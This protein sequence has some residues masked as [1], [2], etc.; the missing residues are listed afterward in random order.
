M[1]AESSSQMEQLFNFFRNQQQPVIRLILTLLLRQNLRATIMT[2]VRFLSEGKITSI[3]LSHRIS[4]ADNW[5]LFTKRNNSL[6]ANTSLVTD[7][8]SCFVWGRKKNCENRRNKIFV[9]KTELKMVSWAR[10]RYQECK[11]ELEN[12]TDTTYLSATHT[13]SVL[14]FSAFLLRLKCASAER[15]NAPSSER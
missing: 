12:F 7:S 1:E 5:A 2:G 15:R 11:N 10:P 6:L 14:Q 13:V 3:S 9:C 4:G 8:Q